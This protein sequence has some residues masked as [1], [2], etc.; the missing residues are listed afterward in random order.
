M[1]AANVRGA[2]TAPASGQPVIV[3]NE[4]GSWLDGVPRGEWRF[5]PDPGSRSY[6][7]IGPG[8][9]LRVDATPDV[10]A[11]AV[12]LAP[13]GKGWA[14]GWRRTREAAVNAAAYSADRR[15]HHL[16]IGEPDTT[17][18]VPAGRGPT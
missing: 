9:V 4:P 15:A 16:S 18:P 1:T 8:V 7:A 10:W 14:R 13:D 12:Y 5:R 17:R 11:W 3:L 2:D 6:R